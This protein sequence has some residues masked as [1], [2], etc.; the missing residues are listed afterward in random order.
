MIY[1]SQAEY[2]NAAEDDDECHVCERVSCEC[3]KDDYFDEPDGYDP[4]KGEGECAW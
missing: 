3:E 2:D 4:H 1:Y